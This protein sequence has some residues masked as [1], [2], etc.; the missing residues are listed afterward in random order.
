MS[1]VIQHRAHGRE[2]YNIVVVGHV[3]HGKSTLI[4]RL[5]ADTGSLP[6]G[7][8]EAVRADCERN[9]KPFEYAF[10]LD[11]LENERKQG[12][13]ID[14][15]RSF[16]QSEKR[17]Y[18]II[19]APGHIEF[20]KNM[21]SGAARAEA[22]VL[23]IDAKEGVRENS[24][25]HGYML[26]LLG[27]K[28]VAVIVNKMD[29]VDWSEARFEA[30]KTEYAEFLAKVG[31]SPRAWI[32]VSAFHGKNLVSRASEMAW[33]K[34]PLLLELMDSFPKDRDPAERP[35]RFPVQDVYKFTEEGDDRRIVAG[36][37]DTGRVKIGD[38]VRFLPSGKSAT[39]KSVEAF[40]APV[41]SS[42]LAG[43]STGFTL[44]PEIYVKPGEIMFLES[45]TPPLS[46]TRI[47]VNLIW[48]GRSP[49]VRDRS[50]K[51]KLATA[52]VTVWLDEIRQVMDASDLSTGGTQEVKLNDVAECVFESAKPIAFD[53]VADCPPT[54]RF[55]LVD[56]YEI[57]GGG[58]VLGQE[59]GSGKVLERHLIERDR[60]FERSSLTPGLR[61]GR[62]G[63]NA[64]LVILAGPD[65][66]RLSDVAKQLEE[67][68]FTQGRYVYFLGLR[69]ATLDLHTES[70]TGDRTDLLYRLGETAYLFAEAGAVVLTTLP[71][72]DA[73][74]LSLLGTLA[75]PHQSLVIALGEGQVPDG[76]ADLV[77]PA[78]LA[79]KELVDLVV[80]FLNDHNVLV[81][82]NL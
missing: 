53:L 58:I 18:V 81:E 27:I 69:N 32:P 11:A 44:D 17:D 72:A 71:G 8:L 47:R 40:N 1:T 63:Q 9:A 12:I 13:T 52:E 33:Y 7:K 56:Q 35:L 38:A 74:E 5:L 48:M 57:A 31:V 26:S 30:I 78:N 2:R 14:T 66:E 23:L 60:A 76:A 25:R 70:G 64:G 54:G 67:R 79:Q 36:R 3:D 62:Y 59:A 73:D 68:F 16:F 29:L 20:L 4:G 75:K 50:Y 37:I 24:R 45:E 42:A 28:Q 34:G 65:A 49:L 82:W 77:L 51:L 39:I 46:G 80:H 61:A 19:D 10:L 22:A 15:A 43:Q 6:E 41:A 21:I 55:V